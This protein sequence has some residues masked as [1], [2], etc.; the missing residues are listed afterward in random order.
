M[1]GGQAHRGQA[2]TD[3]AHFVRARPWR[4]GHEQTIHGTLAPGFLI[5][6]GQ[7]LVKLLDVQPPSEGYDDADVWVPATALETPGT[8]GTRQSEQPDVTRPIE[9]SGGSGGQPSKDR[10]LGAKEPSE[11]LG[12]AAAFVLRSSIHEIPAGQARD[13]AL[14]TLSLTLSEF[15]GAHGT[16]IFLAP[17]MAGM[18]ELSLAI[19]V[20]VSEGT[21]YLWKF[22]LATRPCKTRSAMWAPPPPPLAEAVLRQR[23][24]ANAAHYTGQLPLWL[25]TRQF[26]SV[27]Q[28]RD[29]RLQHVVQ[30]SLP[31]KLQRML[32][33]RFRMQPL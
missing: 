2:H 32:I 28:W 29:G 27:F 18:H 12:E 10:G 4:R 11:H 9:G 23:D 17:G 14:R 30:F 3:D 15:V 26:W 21:D 33:R 5:A 7:V 22:Q 8:G 19:D 1:H 13:Y 25:T 31:D 16:N 6:N 20:P 24:R